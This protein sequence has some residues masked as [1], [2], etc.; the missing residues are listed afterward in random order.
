MDKLKYFYKSIVIYLNLKYYEFKKYQFDK[1]F[2]KFSRYL[3]IYKNYSFK[4][5]YKKIWQ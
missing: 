3:K 1:N 5:D 2:I 4:N